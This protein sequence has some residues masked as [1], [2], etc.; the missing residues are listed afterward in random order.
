MWSE[1]KRFVIIFNGEIYNYQGLKSE[2]QEKGHHFIGGSDTEVILAAAEEWGVENSLKRFSGMCAFALFDTKNRVLHLARDKIGKKPLY[3]GISKGRFVFAS[4]LR[5]FFALPDFYPEVDRVSLARFTTYCYV[6]SPY[7][8]F[9]DVRKLEPGSLLTIPLPAFQSALQS[10]PP[11]IILDGLQSMAA[12]YW[13]P[14]D[15]A[16]QPRIMRSDAD[17][18]EALEVI[19]RRAVRERMISDVPLGAL[20]SGGVDS[21][22]VVALMQA[23]STQKVRTFSIGFNEADFNE[24]HEAARVANHLGTH[25]TELYVTAEDALGVVPKLPEIYDEP[26]SDS[27]QIPT[28]LVSKLARTEVTVCLSGDGGDELFGGYSRYYYLAKLWSM[29]RHLPTP[30]ASVLSALLRCIPAH[31]WESVLK[32]ILPFKNPGDKV[33]RLADVLKIRDP[34]KLYNRALSHWSPKVVIGGADFELK[35]REL[36]RAL[37]EYDLTELIESMVAIDMEN[38]LPEDILTKVDR[39]SMAVSLEARAPLLDTD[40]LEFTWKLPF[41]FKV[42]NGIQKWILKELLYRYVPKPLVDRPKSGFGVPLDSWLRGPLKEWASDLLSEDSL[43]RNGYFDADAVRVMWKE[44]LVGTRNRAHYLW[45]ILMFE[46]WRR[47]YV[48]H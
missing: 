5:S 39:A 43:R 24:A 47:H 16:H 35:A 23:Q 12:K 48:R 33:H 9:T 14:L 7:S 3:Y 6:P 18:L 1:S 19:L 15:F 4:E 26:F 11:K 46:A 2:L 44:H 25:H 17:S 21:S 22:I 42:R 38:Y 20:L 30:V 32:H 29:L 13:S 40:L 45:D 34:L 31:T 37:H 27:S 8:I 41:N 36:R 10:T 28:Y